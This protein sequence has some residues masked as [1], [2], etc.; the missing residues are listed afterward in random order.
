MS[1]NPLKPPNPPIGY[2]LEVNKMP[3]F[4][5]PTAA[6]SKIVAAPLDD[7]AVAEVDSDNPKKILVRDPKN[8]TL[9]VETHEETHVFQFSRN[10]AIVNQWKDNLRKGN[11]TESY[12]YGGMDGLLQAQREHRSITSFGLEQQAD[13]VKDFQQLTDK[14][15]ANKD[16]ALL[17]KV[18]AAYGPYV[19][20]LANLPAKNESMTTMTRRDLTPPPPGLPPATETGI[21]AENKLL[22]S[23]EMFLPPPPLRAKNKGRRH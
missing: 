12:D 9:P 5:R 19:R 17:D 6:T 21:L 3:S 8:F 20:Q 10:P 2:R 18:N 1:P 7:I 13:I 22:G 23:R 14:A 11:L 16:F 4:L 15:I